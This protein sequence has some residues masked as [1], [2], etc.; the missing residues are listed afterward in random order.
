MPL[1]R[2]ASKLD[3]FFDS[4]QDKEAWKAK[5]AAWKMNKKAMEAE[6]EETHPSLSLSLSLPV[7][8]IKTK[9]KPASNEETNGD[10]KP[11]CIK[12]CFLK[13]S[14]YTR[15]SALQYTLLCMCLIKGGL[16]NTAF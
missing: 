13:H 8:P 12:H 4:A 2:S 16:L 3:V 6:E 14:C 7:N 9:K 15:M 10:L 1:K 11:C 5:K